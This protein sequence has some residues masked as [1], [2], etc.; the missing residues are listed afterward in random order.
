MAFRT[1]IPNGDNQARTSQRDGERFIL[2]EGDQTNV[3][4][5]PV[6]TFE[7][8]RVRFIN[9]GTAET[10]GDT[11]TVDIQGDRGRVEN[12]RTGEI[13]A[14]QTAIEISGEDARI[15]NSGSIDGGV[16][17]VNFVN[18]GESSGTLNNF[19]TITSDSRAVNIGGEDISIRNFGQI[20]GTGDQRNGTIY[21]DATAEDFSIFNARSGVIDAGEGNLGAGIALQTGDTP[22]DEV[23]ASVTNNG[24]IA[25][26]GQAAANLGTAGDGIRVFAGTESPTFHGNIVNRGTITSESAQGTVGGIR[27]A[28]GVNFDG[29]I[30]N[31]RGATISGV[32]NGVYFGTGSHDANIINRGTIS[33]DSRAVNIDGTGIDLVNS[34]Q[35]LGTGNQRNGTVYA[36]ATADDYSINNQRRALIDAGE[37]NQGA[38]IALQTG[39]VAND[40]VNASISNSGVINGRGQAAANLG[41]AGDGIRIFAGA[42][43]PTFDGNIINRGTITSESAQGTVGGIR[44]ANGVNF[45]GNIVNERGAT[46]SGVQNGVYFGTGSHDANII[47]RGT[48]S[49][50]SRAVNI[51][52]TGVDLVNF[53]RILG[54]GDQRNGTVYSDATADDYSITNQRRAL[55]DAG[56]GNQGAGIALQTGD[57]ANDTVTASITNRGVI[58]GR[59]QAAPDTGLAGDGIRIFAG[60]DNPTFQGDINNFGRITSESDQGPV[61]AIRIAN[62]VNFDGTINNFGRID[63]DNNGL[64]FG[65]GNHDAHVNNRGTISSDS[66][67]VNIDG[68]GVEL[69]NFGRIL[70][71]GDQRNGTVYA[72]DIADNYEVNNFRGAVIDAGRGNNGS[73]V[74]LQTGEVDGDTVTA[75]LTNSG[76]ILGR[77][78]AVDGNTVGDGVRLFS[79]QSDVTFTGN[80]E[81]RGFIGG[82]SDSDVAVGLSIED[83]ITLDG[84][85]INR[86]TIQGS[87][88][89]ID[90]TE[91]GGNVVIQNSGLV[92]GD[93]NLSAGNDT[94]DGT[95]GRVFGDIN[96][97]GGEDTISGGSNADRINGGTDNDTLSGGRGRDTFVFEENTGS[98]TVADFAFR[99]DSLDVGD[100]FNDA[101]TALAAAAQDGDD[102][103]VT[104]S[105][106]G[107]AV[108]L[109]GVD[110]DDL[111]A[112]NFI[113]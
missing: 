40:T 90:V 35:I 9:A 56:H 85:I 19:G 25:G 99:F 22:G 53:G 4:G 23:D 2:G 3:D 12:L 70:G 52:G 105:N 45:D 87:E 43:N 69:N 71:T 81:N 78:D 7:D 28:N 8:D 1:F 91:A 5:A 34:G 47:N 63:G 11:A 112:S 79:A 48:I 26:R 82:S 109:V 24:T 68:S 107:D 89:A 93:V 60:A 97:G 103:V 29:N 66:R 18:G 61:G 39:D 55:I 98:D 13:N 72:D 54:T 86:G 73:G 30:V 100:F 76:A 65:T 49:S 64:Y 16:N 31:E 62:G 80:I 88:V 17:G 50:D 46:I 94:F 57:V 27:V 32:Q 75:S 41:T 51:D 104:L 96:G 74:S 20:L 14:E 92:R 10:T 33:S 102:T 42:E 110:V 113:V 106:S 6:I 83:G 59:G 44:V 58:N 111:Q 37:G 67:A 101:S 108:R 38:G 84:Q 77:G 15:N 36:D 21:S 95:R